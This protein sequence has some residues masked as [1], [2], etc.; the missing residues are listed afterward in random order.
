MSWKESKVRVLAHQGG[1]QVLSTENKKAS[2][3]QDVFLLPPSSNSTNSVP[4]HPTTS[5]SLSTALPTSSHP[6]L[7][8]VKFK[9]PLPP[10]PVSPSSSV[11][12]QPHSDTSNKSL[13]I[14]NL[15]SDVCEA[16]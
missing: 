11:L 7:S 4:V 3:I 5:N 8:G 16:V 1:L 10:Q 15:P 14:H 6:S 12:Q 9:I 2:D 13:I